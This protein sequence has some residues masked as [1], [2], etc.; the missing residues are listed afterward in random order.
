MHL[1]SSHT[2]RE[3]QTL[4]LL[5]GPAAAEEPQQHQH[6]PDGDAEKAH[7][8]E[9]HG[10]A[11]ERPQQLEEGAPVHT[12]PDPHGQQGQAAQLREDPEKTPS[13]CIQIPVTDESGTTTSWIYRGCNPHLTSAS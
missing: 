8:D 9:L 5:V 4:A 1:L 10:L 13:A 12:H 2:Y 3:Q 6:G 11:G 7:V